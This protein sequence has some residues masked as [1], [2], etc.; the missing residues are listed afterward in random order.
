MP[1]PSLRAGDGLLEGAEE[2]AWV[3][4]KDEVVVACEV[5]VLDATVGVLV[6]AICVLIPFGGVVTSTLI[7]S[8]DIVI[9][10]SGSPIPIVAVPAAH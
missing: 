1:R 7:R 4:V 3:P 5:D 8:P 9:A 10:V 2:V 6:A